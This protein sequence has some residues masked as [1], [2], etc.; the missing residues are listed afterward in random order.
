ML[1]IFAKDGVYVSK[2][3]IRWL[4]ALVLADLDGGNWKADYRDGCGAETQGFWL[5]PP[6]SPL[7]QGDSMHCDVYMYIVSCEIL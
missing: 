6:W 4:P 3:T 1:Q 7:S 5:L 2:I